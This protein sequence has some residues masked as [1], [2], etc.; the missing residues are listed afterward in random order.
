MC[1]AQ[2]AKQPLK[3]YCIMCQISD[4]QVSMAVG[5][6]MVINDLDCDVE[7]LEMKDFVNE[8]EE[9]AQYLIGLASLSRI[10]MSNIY[11]EDSNPAQGT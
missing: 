10:G 4:R 8:P 11:S 7:D 9:T 6:P 1:V 3:A 5:A 2:S